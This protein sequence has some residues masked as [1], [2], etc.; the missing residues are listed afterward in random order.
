MLAATLIRAEA[1]M[2]QPP[3]CAIVGVGPGNGAA[4]A[5]RF[6]KAGYA[7]ALLA[8]NTKY[9]SALA[10]DLPGA[11][12]FVCDAADPASVERAFTAVKMSLGAPEVLI[13]NAGA[14]LFG[15]IE[16]IEMADFE[17]AWRLNAYGGALAARAVI[18][19]M[20]KAGKGAILFIGATASRRG[21]ANFAA[22]APAKAAQKSLAES[23]AR[24]LG[25]K[26]IHVAVLMIDGI[27][28][29]SG[30]ETAAN[31]DGVV[32]VRPVDVARVALQICRQ[33]PSTWSFE[34]EVRPYAERW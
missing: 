11:A 8:R 21:G 19:A 12:A 10:A 22:F 18:P 23:M 13:Y 27:V 2:Q 7:V 9:T 16:E 30:R 15:N 32:Y 17:A 29:T 24:Y 1:V 14:G 28:A 25:P 3:V 20:K 6:A 31:P 34:T 4:F 5:R 33:S 26:G